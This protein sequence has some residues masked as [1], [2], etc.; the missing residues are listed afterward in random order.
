ML[1]IIFAY[2]LAL[3]AAIFGLW[4]WQKNR[5][6]EIKNERLNDE[7]RRLNSARLKNSGGDKCIICLSNPFEI[8]FQPCGHI[9][10]CQDCSRKLYEKSSSFGTKCPIC[11]TVIN[12]SQRIYL[13]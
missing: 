6:E 13:S 11:R 10:A 5:Q 4:A 9:C 1:R 2:L 7:I 12:G 8:L 3:I